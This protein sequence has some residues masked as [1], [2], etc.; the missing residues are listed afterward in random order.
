[1]A[2]SWGDFSSWMQNAAPGQEGAA[3]P[4][5]RGEGIGGFFDIAGQAFGGQNTPFGGIAT[6]ML[7]NKNK[8]NALDEEWKKFYAAVR[9]PGVKTTVGEDNTV[10]MELPDTSTV[11]KL[12]GVAP[13]SNALVGTGGAGYG[14]PAGSIGGGGYGNPDLLAMEKSGV[15]GGFNPFR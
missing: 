3:N 7:G 14:N 6:Q 8:Q 15:G 5:T 9:T 13:S 10:K 11:S 12:G 1:M 4:I 2:F